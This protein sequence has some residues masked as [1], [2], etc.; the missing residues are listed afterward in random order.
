MERIGAWTG[1]AAS[2]G[3]HRTSR[4][5]RLGG[6]LSA[7]A[8]A[9][10]QGRTRRFG[11]I[12]S[13]A[14]SSTGRNPGSLTRPARSFTRALREG[15]M[16]ET[17]N[18][19]EGP[20][21]A[22][23]FDTALFSVF[24]LFDKFREAFESCPVRT[25][26]NDPQIVLK[27]LQGALLDPDTSGDVAVEEMWETIETAQSET[28]DRVVFLVADVIIAYAAQAIRA[29]D[30]AELEAGWKHFGDA[31]YWEGILNGIRMRKLLMP[32]N[33]TASLKTEN[34]ASLMALRRHAASAEEKRRII[35]YWRAHID[36][37]LSAAKAATLIV[38]S[39]LFSLEFRTIQTVIAAERKR[40]R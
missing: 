17:V 19:S 2:V 36:P 9:S 18:N 16:A 6:G 8:A 7:W 13:T 23:L 29:E 15:A 4:P 1:A 27:M 34:P 12:A 33:D 28:D 31:R 26:F 21:T 20:I 35:E 22:A 10:R 32:G 5:C 3:R 14:P 38:T 11:I 37:S 40:S 39:G 25:V 24:H 30:R